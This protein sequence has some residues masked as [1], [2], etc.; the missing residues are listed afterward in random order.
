[1]KLAE[2][3]YTKVAPHG[4][5]LPSDRYPQQHLWE[6]ASSHDEQWAP[7][8]LGQQGYKPWVRS[9]GPLL[10]GLQWRREQRV[11]PEMLFAEDQGMRL[12]GDRGRLACCLSGLECGS[13]VK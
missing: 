1:M 4:Q 7:V 9:L 13:H 10:Q 3:C 2:D 6:A 8:Q 5:A 12:V 11:D